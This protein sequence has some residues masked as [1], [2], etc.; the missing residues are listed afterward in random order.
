L[1]ARPSRPPPHPRERHAGARRSGR[2]HLHGRALQPHALRDRA[3]GHPQA[4][5]DRDSP[6]RPRLPPP[7]GTDPRAST[8]TTAPTTRRTRPTSTPKKPRCARAPAACTAEPSVPGW[9]RG[10][11]MLGKNETVV[12]A[13]KVARLHPSSSAVPV[14][15]G[16]RQTQSAGRQTQSG[17]RQTQSGGRQTRSGGRQ[18][19]SA[20]RQTQSGGRQTRSAGRQTQSGGRQT[21]SAGRQNTPQRKNSLRIMG[22]GFGNLFK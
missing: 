6:V 17:G 15:S 1:G 13:L 19:R 3:G 12:S 9:R 2:Q 10:R 14:R 21:R 7:S 8:T 5:A 4:T 11:R 20:G 18:T 16:G 22:F